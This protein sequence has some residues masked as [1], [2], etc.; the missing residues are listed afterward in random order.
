MN[1]IECKK[2]VKDFLN[3]QPS[4]STLMR[5]V[6]SKNKNDTLCVLSVINDRLLSGNPYI[7]E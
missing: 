5:E 1:N 3:H 4:L 7:R 2:W 6:C